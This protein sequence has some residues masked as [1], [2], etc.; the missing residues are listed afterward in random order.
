MN[1]YTAVSKN[2]KYEIV[3]KSKGLV[4]PGACLRA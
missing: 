1:M 4:P 2:G 3:E